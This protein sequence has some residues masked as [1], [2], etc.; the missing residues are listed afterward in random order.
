MSTARSNV[1]IADWSGKT[2]SPDGDR[3]VTDESGSDGSPLLNALRTALGRVISTIRTF[4]ATLPAE[5]RRTEPPWFGDY[6]K[7]EEA[8]YYSPGL[9]SLTDDGDLPEWPGPPKVTLL[10]VDPYLVHA[11][12][13]FDLAKLPPDTTAAILR[14]YDEETHF[15]VDVDLRTRNW[16]VPLW[17]PAKTYYADLGAI[18]A[19]GEFIPLVRSNTVQTPRAWPLA[20]VGH[21]FVS[22]VAASPPSDESVLPPTPA[23]PSEHAGILEITPRA[24]GSPT[25]AEAKAAQAEPAV[26]FSPSTG[27]QSSASVVTAPPTEPHIPKPGDAAEI[28][29]RRLSE[30]HEFLQGQPQAQ[31]A[32]ENLPAIPPLPASPGLPDDLTAH[33]ERQFSPGL[34]SLFQGGQDPRKPAG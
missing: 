11:Y 19:A 33:A 1:E 9:P 6:E 26:S 15:D 2:T 29:G 31:R 22:D 4:A 7:V 28:L 30:I 34:S 13:D 14:F 3:D 25:A 17:S 8:K 20:E 16:Y 10:A 18:T 23:F 24:S 21:R 12:W 5:K 32:V 27:H